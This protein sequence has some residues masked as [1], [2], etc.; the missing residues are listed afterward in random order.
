M[1][2]LEAVRPGA[3]LV[4]QVRPRLGSAIRQGRCAPGEHLGEELLSRRF[5]IGRALLRE[6]MAHAAA[7]RQS[8]NE[9]RTILSA[10]ADRDADRAEP[11]LRQPIARS[12]ARLA[13]AGSLG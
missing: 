2:H 13:A 8:P 4:Q 5:G 9:H 12:A 6:A 3:P 1:T 7:A 11:L 10:L